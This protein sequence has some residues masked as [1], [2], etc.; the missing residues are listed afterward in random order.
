M[1]PILCSLVFAVA[2]EAHID[3]L[4]PAETTAGAAGFT[5][6]AI[7]TEF[8]ASEFLIWNGTP[9]QTTFV[10]DLELRATIPASFLLNPGTVQVT[11]SGFNTVRFVINPPPVIT[12]P[13]PL[14]NGAP[15]TSYARLLER[16]GGT[17]PFRWSVSSGTLPE[18]LTLNETSGLLS[19]TPRAAG[20]SN[21]TIRLID[22]VNIATT[23][24]FALTIG[25]AEPATPSCS[26]S[27]QNTY[28]AAHHPI[29]HRIGGRVPDHTIRVAASAGSMPIVGATV[30]LTATRPVFPGTTARAV[31]DSNGIAT[32]TI[33]PP[34]PSGFDQTTL[35]A[36]VVRGA[37]TLRCAG[38]VLAGIG[39]LSSIRER[40]GGAEA[41]ALARLQ[42]RSAGDAE[43]YSDELQRIV[44]ADPG[45]QDE[46]VEV[47][48]R[49]GPALDELLA[50]MPI[51]VRGSEA[52]RLRRF[53]ET[54][55]PRASPA[56]RQAI[57]GWTRD[58]FEV[59]ERFRFADPPKWRAARFVIGTPPAAASSRKLTFE[60]NFGQA[61]AGTRYLA[62]GAAHRALFT[63]TGLTLQAPLAEP[64]HIGFP[65]A[66]F[67]R[68]ELLE[69]DGGRSH[70]LQGADPARWRRN[71]PHYQ[72]L[73][74]SNLVAG[75]DLVFYGDE[76]RLRYDFVVAPRANPNRIAVSFDGVREIEPLPTGE[77]LLH[78]AGGD[79]RLGAPY[80]YQNRDGHSSAIA[81]RY[82]SRGGNR[83][84]FEL[85]SY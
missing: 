69:P 61:G 84:G 31:T 83:V 38:T 63:G 26:V 74:Y 36:T 9:L 23:K 24:A 25:Q 35:N 7:G 27:P 33:N 46:A 20:T 6:R 29:A 4:I 34:A 67:S 53:F 54:I 76:G 71:I 72:R 57:A 59:R 50:G 58:L 48:R 43:T 45:L 49:F 13:S 51:R 42:N 19:G 52:T 66:R 16:T 40:F 28:L 73:R 30:D 8:E 15:A 64:V 41:Q 3:L 70:V 37:E 62:K 47:L 21:F 11:L 81:A 55:G 68:A 2:L 77:L 14:P 60:E 22:S 10:S 56:L 65:G 39:V 78:Y 80:V 17:A 5:L 12:T 18:G 75:V 85:A 1:R 82:V 44:E 32:F 79:I